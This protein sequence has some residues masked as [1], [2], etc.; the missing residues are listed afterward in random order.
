MTFITSCFS[1]LRAKF[2]NLVIDHHRRV[3]GKKLVAINQRRMS[4]FIE[5]GRRE[6]IIQP[7]TDIVLAR[8]ASIRPPRIMYR[9]WADQL[10]KRVM[11]SRF[12]E[13]REPRALLGQKAAVLLVAAPIFQI[14]L[15]MSDIEIPA[16]HQVAFAFPQALAMSQE[17]VHELQLDG[18][19]LRAARARWNIG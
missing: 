10:A 12:Q 7:P 14:D 5:R 9:F 6:V 8:S 15:L 2:L 18:E 4:H 16:K 11:V 13:S 1:L 3:I 17:F 19:T